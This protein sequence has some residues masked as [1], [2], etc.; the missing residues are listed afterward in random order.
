MQRG[1]GFLHRGPAS[2]AQSCAWPAEG[3]PTEPGWNSALVVV[4]LRA[5]CHGVLRLTR[6]L[7]DTR[8]SLL[9]QFLLLEV[10]ERVRAA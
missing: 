2:H 1:V 6:H 7:A 4:T 8:R 9:L 10:T 3:E 5:R